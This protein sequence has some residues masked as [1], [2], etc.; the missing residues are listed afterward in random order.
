MRRWLRWLPPSLLALGG[1]AGGITAWQLEA[2]VPPASRA[3]AVARHVVTPVLSVRR[4]PTVVAAPIA[5]RRLSADLTDLAATLPPDSC[6]AV[7]GPEDLQF[8]HRA[9]ASMVPAS[10]AKLLTATAALVALGPDARF[11]TTVVASA[12][13]LDGGLAGDLTLVGGGDPILESPDYTARFLRQP[14]IVTDLDGLAADI[15]EA[16]VQRVDGAIVGDESRYDQ[17]RYVSGWPERYISQNQIGPLS[18]LA[19]NDGFE[20]YPQLGGGGDPLVAAADPAA[21][22]AAVL[23]R[24]L[25]ARGVEVVGEPRRGLAPAGAVEVAA[26]E[27]PPLVDVVGQLL[28]ESDNNTG[29]LLL[30]EL[31]RG[32]GDPTT[33]GGATA[34]QAQLAEGGVD[35][36]GSVVADGSGLSLDDRVT[37]DLL[38]DLLSRPGTGPLLQDRLAVAGQSGTLTDRYVD[39]PLAGTLRAKTGSLN[40]VSSLAGLVADEDPALL[41]ALVVNVPAP[42]RVPDSAVAA[43]QRLGEILLSWPRVPDVAMLG[44]LTQD[45]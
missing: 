4:A 42:D 18:G 35:L 45:G 2:A 20:R 27:S 36:S 44:P 19:V 10:T 17:A 26:V 30:K 22:A 41:F 6:L 33:P 32:G 25:E 40:T 23:T 38:V 34:A 3:E 28:Q 43:Q 5:E 1:L 37:C 7:E 12:P 11:R 13:P 15:Q 21:N 29:E 9:D 24:L 14:Q 31:G 39:T 8:G 16:G